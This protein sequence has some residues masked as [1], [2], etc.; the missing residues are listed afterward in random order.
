ML[1]YSNSVGLIDLTREASFLGDCIPADSA[2]LYKL[3][4]YPIN[5]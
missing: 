2:F 5:E 4:L 1:I 3:F